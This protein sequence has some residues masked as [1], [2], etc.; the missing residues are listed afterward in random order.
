MQAIAL[1]V[2]VGSRFAIL[3]ARLYDH[4]LL[5]EGCPADFCCPLERFSAV[6]HYLSLPL[7]HLVLTVEYAPDGLA[8]PVVVLRVVE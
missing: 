8:G 2:V 4:P 1:V 5:A 6:R 7:L 3:L